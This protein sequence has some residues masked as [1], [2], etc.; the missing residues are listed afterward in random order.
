[1]LCPVPSSGP[2]GGRGT[3][4]RKLASIFSRKTWD[5][6]RFPSQPVPTNAREF[7]ALVG[8]SSIVPSHLWLFDEASG[9]FIDR[10]AGVTLTPAGDTTQLLRSRRCVGLLKSSGPTWHTG[11]EWKGNTGHTLDIPSV[12]GAG[13]FDIADP[14]SNG[15]RFAIGIKYRASRM[16]GGVN[17][18]LLYKYNNSRGYWFYLA[19]S[20]SGNYQIT[21]WNSDFAN[22]VSVTAGIYA[23]DQA[24]HELWVVVDFGAAKTITAYHDGVQVLAP[25]SLAVLGANYSPGNA[26]QMGSFFG[27]PSMSGQI[28]QLIILHGTSAL[29][30]STTHAARLWKLDAKPGGLTTY[31]SS[32]PAAFCVNESPTYGEEWVAYNGNRPAFKKSKHGGVELAM[33]AAA[34][35]ILSYTHSA[36]GFSA[37]VT[38]TP[39]AV[40][41]PTGCR[42][43]ASFV[44]TAQQAFFRQSFNATLGTKYTFGVV[45]WSNVDGVQCRIGHTDAG[46]NTFYAQSIITLTTKP[47]LF[48]FTSTGVATGVEA[49]SVQ[50]SPDGNSAPIG[51]TVYA[52][53]SIVRA[54]EASVGPLVMSYNSPSTRA[55]VNAQAVGALAEFTAEAAGCLRVEA[56]V[57]CDNLSTQQFF[58]SL[59]GGNDKRQIQLS[60]VEQY[61]GNVYDSAGAL[62]PPSPSS[63]VNAGLSSKKVALELQWRAATPL[64]DEVVYTELRDVSDPNAVVE[65]NG[66]AS[67]F[68]VGSTITTLRLG[69]DHAGNNPLE[70]GIR[71]VQTREV[72]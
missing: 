42:D 8:D 20:G 70:G 14:G 11:I 64:P 63:G 65:Y 34:A 47:K 60:T 5:F 13:G 41:G 15:G 6:R 44:A 16:V 12:P 68:T 9:S 38:V 49:L 51:R 71:Y 32:G 43:A 39:Q 52:W 24:W 57:D 17:Q 45:M 3:L 28:K 53:H 21:L 31:S 69:T 26:M 36:S 10:I 40:D 7:S 27:H 58:A 18:T 55:A 19:D 23:F 48:T 62:T 72:A 67:S 37:L 29:N 33:H 35:S 54:H 50:L 25:T 30:F 22:T 1:M 2:G 59:H 46:T 56:S 4:T 66:K 61:V